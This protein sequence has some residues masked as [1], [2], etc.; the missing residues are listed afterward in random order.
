MNS[1]QVNYYARMADQRE[2]DPYGPDGSGRAVVVNGRGFQKWRRFN[3]AEPVWVSDIDGR[4]VGLTPMQVSVLLLSR[5]L[6]GSHATMRSMATT[7]NCSPSTVSRA[8]V[9]LASFGLIAYLTAR[10]RYAGTVILMRVKGDGLDRFR[11]LAKAKVREWS[12]A[13]ARRLSRLE[14]NVAPYVLGGRRGRDSLT[15]YVL[16]T[17]YVQD[18][19][20]KPWVIAD[21]AK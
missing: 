4:M 2:R 9:K 11:A 15:D 18:A 21:D 17:K 13:A 1:P 6:V 8:L 5:E 19:T 10:G 7:L 20:L 16:S 14:I 3:K 12:L